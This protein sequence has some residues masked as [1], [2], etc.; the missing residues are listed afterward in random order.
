M[1]GLRGTRLDHFPLGDLNKV[2]DLIHFEGPLLSLFRNNGG[3]KYLY[4]WCDSGNDTNRWLVFRVSDREL[5]SYLTKR[6]TLQDLLLSP[7]DGFIYV[8][9]IKENMDIASVYIL[10]PRELPS[11]YNADENSYYEFT[12]SSLLIADHT[13]GS[14][15]SE[16]Y[17]IVIDGNWT[18]QDLA[19][20]PKIYSTVYA[21][22]YSLRALRTRTIESL[23]HVYQ[24]H[25]WRGGYS[26]LNFFNSLKAYIDPKD[27]L[28]I[29]SMRYAS[30]GWIELNISSP[31]AF[32]VKSIVASFVA[33][34]AEL[35]DLYKGIYGELRARE[36]LRGVDLSSEDTSLPQLGLPL[37]VRELDV[38]QKL[39][40]KRKTSRRLSIQDEQFASKSAMQLAGLLKLEREDFKQI[41][42]LTGNPLTT[43]KILLAVYRRIRV[44]AEYHVQGKADY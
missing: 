37:E 3:D 26:S 20:M 44:L 39:R 15:P 1:K 41:N 25:S 10:D 5:D 19:E 33:S 17:K 24:A 43:L 16:T 6:A 22:I 2:T 42:S 32:S 31:V 21:F 13:L 35:E 7:S 27:R 14:K 8:A 4:Y 9:D 18:L 23:R 28:Q 40:R 38:T 34:A 11:D 30:P 29:V 36:L 12:P